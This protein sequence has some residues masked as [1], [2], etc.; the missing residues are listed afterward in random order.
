MMCR[1]T[2]EDI[3]KDA[4]LQDSVKRLQTYKDSRVHVSGL[5]D[6]KYFYNNEEAV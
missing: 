1:S 2:E 3:Q 4:L 6:Y 5:G